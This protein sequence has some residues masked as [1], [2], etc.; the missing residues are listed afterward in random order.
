MRYFIID[1][2]SVS[3]FNKLLLTLNITAEIHNNPIHAFRRITAAASPAIIFLDMSMPDM[4]GKEFLNRLAERNNPNYRVVIVSG[5]DHYDYL[6]AALLNQVVDY[7]LKP[8]TL[9]HLKD[10]IDRAT[11][12]PAPNHAEFI[13]QR[14]SNSYKVKFFDGPALYFEI[15]QA[16]PFLHDAIKNKN[17][18]VPFDKLIPDVTNEI[19][20]GRIKQTLR[21]FYKKLNSF[22]P[23]FKKHLSSFVHVTQKGLIYSPNYPLTWLL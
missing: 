18:F 5:W 23:V 16:L 13:F 15:V 1:D 3:G 17:T 8:V 22:D 6:R 20:A 14:V 2:E 11:N 4:S 19:A 21:T 10:V 9:E 7:L 12:G